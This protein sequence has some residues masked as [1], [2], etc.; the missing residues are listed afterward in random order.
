MAI[1]SAFLGLYC[2]LC[3]VFCVMFAIK[4]AFLWFSFAILLIVILNCHFK[5]KLKIN[6]LFFIEEKW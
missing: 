3:T 5:V 1:E 6:K 2:V 4:S